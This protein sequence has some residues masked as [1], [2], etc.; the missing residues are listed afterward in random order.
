MSNNRV[1]VQSTK[2]EIKELKTHQ[3]YGQRN[4]GEI[5]HFKSAND[6]PAN[7]SWQKARQFI[8]R[9]LELY[10]NAFMFLASNN[11]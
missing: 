7:E 4:Y 11:V 2:N 1:R 3:Y 9:H 8:P 5:K 10:V 6:F